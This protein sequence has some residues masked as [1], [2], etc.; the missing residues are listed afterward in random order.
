[1]KIGLLDQH[2]GKCKLIDLCGEPYSDVCI[3]GKIAFEEMTEA[4]YLKAA[5]EVQKSGRRKSY[6]N[7]DIEK[8]ICETWIQEERRCKL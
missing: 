5:E 7:R 6:S 8:I 1:M 2:C 3:C 4:E